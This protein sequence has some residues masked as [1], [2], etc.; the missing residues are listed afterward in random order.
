MH[1]DFK[2]SPKVCLVVYVMECVVALECIL[3]HMNGVIKQLTVLNVTH[4]IANRA[5]DNPTSQLN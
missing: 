1:D 4:W 3:F 5:L 2:H